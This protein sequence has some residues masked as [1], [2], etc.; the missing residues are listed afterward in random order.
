MHRVLWE[1]IVDSKV[2]VGFLEIP[3]LALLGKDRK[4]TVWCELYE[5]FSKDFVYLQVGGAGPAPDMEGYFDNDLKDVFEAD[6]DPVSRPCLMI[7]VI[8]LV[9]CCHFTGRSVGLGVRYINSR[10]KR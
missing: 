3:S 8:V 7:A 4:V 9:W 5:F 2:C 10:E 1:F 6:I